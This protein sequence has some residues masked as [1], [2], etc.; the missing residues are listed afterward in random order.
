MM[1]RQYQPVL[2]ILT[3]LLLFAVAPY[4][5]AGGGPPAGFRAEFL[6]QVDYVQQQ[7][8][9][10]EQAIPQEKFTW[11]PGE[12]V[13]SISEVYLH[14]AYANY[15]ILKQAGYEPPTE[16]HFDM[17]GQK[18]EAATTDKATIAEALKKS[19]DHVRATAI[20]I[21]DTDL[22]KK[23]IL[24]GNE[25]TVR[26]AL[27]TALSHLHEHLG[28]SIAYAR[29]NGVVPPWTAAEMKAKEKAKE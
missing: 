10:L 12:G 22:E 27:V 15:L 16:A 4:G 20:K 17:G 24:F 29:M 8:T 2:S 18:W 3:L 5:K 11:R 21:T 13:R 26:N 19:F 28:Q 23:V 14:V 6:G 9:D 7:I 25:T 1:P